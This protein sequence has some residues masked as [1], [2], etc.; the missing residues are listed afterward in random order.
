M[1]HHSP[2]QQNVQPNPGRSKPEKQI[3][4]NSSLKCTQSS[5]PICE[6]PS[7]IYA[8]W[9][10]CSQW[11]APRKQQ[12]QR[13][14]PEGQSTL[15]SLFANQ[16]TLLQTWLFHH[17]LLMTS[18]PQTHLRAPYLLWRA[19]NPRQPSLVF[20]PSPAHYRTENMCFFISKILLKIT[21]S[22]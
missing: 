13:E 17:S 20:E 14:I 11:C 2:Y 18:S 21:P 10:I 16:A 6:P 8:S 15:C 4:A 1:C 5:C 9:N 22:L 3:K 19:C 7:F 12:T